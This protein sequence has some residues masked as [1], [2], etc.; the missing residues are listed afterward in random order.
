MASRRR[1]LQLF[2]TAAVGAIA[3]C[4]DDARDG[5]TATAE[6]ETPP[7]QPESTIEPDV[8]T[9]HQT[10]LTA[11]DGDEWDYFGSAVAVS[12]D[13]TTALIG[14]RLDEEPNGTDG[15]AAYVFTAEGGSWTQQSKLTPADGEST[16]EFG[17]AVAVSS[18]G[19]TALVGTADDTDPDGERVGAG[20]I[21]AADSGSWTQQAKL[22]MDDADT[23]DNFVEA[24]ALSSDGTTALVGTPIDGDPNGLYAG[25][26]Y[27]FGGVDGSWTQQAKLVPDDGD[28]ND[29]FGYSVAVSGDGTTALIGARLD[30]DPNGRNAGSAYIFEDNGGSWRQQTKLSPDDGEVAAWFGESVGLSDAGTTALIGAVNQD[31]PDDVETGATFVFDSANGAWDHEATLTPDRGSKSDLFGGSVAVSRDGTTALVGAKNSDQPNGRGAGSAYVFD[32]TGDGWTLRRELT[33]ESRNLNDSFGASLDVSNDGTTA[34]VG[35]FGEPNAE[36]VGSAYVFEL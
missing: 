29:G 8:L 21:F 32:V 13:G 20:Y 18:D 19:T 31:G 23:S 1:Y 30:E 2:S 5:G 12:G 24:V 4:A 33:S 36:F 3:G 17:N 10:K 7:T 27:V 14:A 16:E 35:A 34:L 25:S 6:Q 11:A 15:G 9:T 22:D 28:T 26:A